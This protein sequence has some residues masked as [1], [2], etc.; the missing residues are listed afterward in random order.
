MLEPN[1]HGA[2]A[3][4]DDA[5]KNRGKN[6]Q[7]DG[8]QRDREQTVSAVEEINY[9]SGASQGGADARPVQDVEALQTFEHASKDAERKAEAD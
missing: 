9:Q 6:R 1:G 4:Y 2:Q 7:D 8:E 5:A 3:E